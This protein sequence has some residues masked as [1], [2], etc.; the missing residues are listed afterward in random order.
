[1][2]RRAGPPTGHRA[3][4]PAGRPPGRGPA[5][6][7][8][9]RTP[10]PAGPPAPRSSRSAVRRRQDDARRHPAGHGRAVRW[11][12]GGRSGPARRVEPDEPRPATGRS[13]ARRWTGHGRTG[14]ARSRQRGP[15][16]AHRPSRRRADRRLRRAGARRVAATSC[17][18]ERT[19]RQR[20]RPASHRRARSGRRPWAGHRAA[21]RR[22]RR[23]RVL[24]PCPGPVRPAD[25]RG[26]R[27]PVGGGA[28]HR[29]GRCL[30]ARV[31]C[32]AAWRPAAATCRP[33]R[34]CRPPRIGVD[35]PRS[36]KRN[37]GHPRCGWPSSR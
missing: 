9:S 11:S 2:R 16:P 8:G 35:V 27:P 29:P 6:R 3:R 20:H 34:A 33:A 12:S 24:H 36:R 13:A 14:S 17:P 19:H 30:R 23:R 5:L 25:R 22:P 10:L 28:P 37:E 26:P 15:G 31:R 1:M 18:R 7:S 4:E 32:A 21:P